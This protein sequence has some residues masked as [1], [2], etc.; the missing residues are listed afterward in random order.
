M[1]CPSNLVHTSLSFAGVYANNVWNAQTFPFLSQVSDKA[2]ITDLSISRPLPQ[3]LFYP[4]GTEYDQTLILNDDYTVNATKLAEQGLPWFASTQVVAK[5]GSSL[6]F[7]AT[8]T[9]MIIWNGKQVW[10]SI[11]T[12]RTGG[13]QDGVWRSFMSG[14]SHV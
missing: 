9:H 1:D 13:V 3:L 4:N 2:Y 7:G 14:L 6:A 5:I 8:V 12:A 11:K 10:D